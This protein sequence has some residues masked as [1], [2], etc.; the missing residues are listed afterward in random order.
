MFFQQGHMTM[1]SIEHVPGTDTLKVVTRLDYDLFLRD[2]Q[3]TINDD[4][5]LE[6]LRKQS[7]FPAD[8]AIKYFNSKVSI[9]INR[10]H[11]A[12]EFLTMEQAGSDIILN[13][14]Y[15]LEKKPKSLTVS[16]TML[17]GIF[18]DVENLVIIRMKEFERGVKFTQ[19][20]NN[21][22]FILD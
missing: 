6:F 4:V 13:I 5:E 16:N 21:E 11:L 3:Q 19:K 15:H 7:S 2:Y 10:K 14:F 17:T 9:L 20:H 22:T 8:Q 12:G 1:T 18:H